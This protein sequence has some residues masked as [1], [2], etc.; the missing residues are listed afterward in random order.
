MI[1][2]VT[3]TV[4]QGALK[5]DQTLPFSDDTRVKLTIG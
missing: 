3:G 5:L 1:A 2:H 4:E